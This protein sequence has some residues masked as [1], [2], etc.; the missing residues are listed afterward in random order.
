MAK[1]TGIIGIQGTVGGLTFNKNGTISQAQ[2][3][4]AITAVRTLE[5]N[6]E[7][8]NA[9]SSGKTARDAFRQVI[10]NISDSLVVSRMVKK[11]REIIAT[12]AVNDRG[13][14]GVIDAEI[15]LLN[16][17]DFNTKSTL[18]TVAYMGFMPTIVRVS[19]AH[20]IDVDAF[21][22]SRDISA[23][24]GATHVKLVASAASIDFE[25]KTSESVT[26]TSALIPLTNV[27]VVA[28]SLALPLGAASVSPI[29]VVFGI[30]FYQSVN[31]KEYLLGN[32]AYTS[33]QIVA[34]DGNA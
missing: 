17:F 34:V 18:S 11:M 12:D 26:E 4:R 31:G 7:F 32:G 5:N 10:S 22:P 29:A 19:G 8:G 13:Q 24:T 6:V 14:R 27:D 16:G 25:A 30:E 20:K 28:Q 23:P 3:S 33:A 2:K 9:A 1:Q 21:N 15:E